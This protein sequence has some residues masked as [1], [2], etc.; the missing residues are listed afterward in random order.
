M[1][2]QLNN[3]KVLLAVVAAVVAGVAV[4]TGAVDISFLFSLFSAGA[5]AQ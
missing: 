4:Y 3:N 2:E 5:G 1:L